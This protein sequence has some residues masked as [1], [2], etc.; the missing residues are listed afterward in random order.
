VGR[1]SGE[2]YGAQIY[3]SLSALPERPDRVVHQCLADKPVGGHYGV[4][5]C[6]LS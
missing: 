3:E 2:V 5:R 1:M 4:Y 6:S